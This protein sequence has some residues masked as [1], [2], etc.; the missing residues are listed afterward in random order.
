LDPASETPLGRERA[1][2]EERLP[3][4]RITHGDADDRAKQSGTGGGWRMFMEV[5]RLEW[6]PSEGP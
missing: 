6:R 3:F 1:G 4:A 2:D 5:S